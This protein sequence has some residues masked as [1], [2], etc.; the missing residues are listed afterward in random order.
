M[1]LPTR[2][3][4]VYA[5]HAEEKSLIQWGMRDFVF[6]GLRIAVCRGDEPPTGDIAVVCDFS[7]PIDLVME[8]KGE[9]DR[10]ADVCAI[11]EKSDLTLVYGTEM[12]V[13]GERRLSAVIA[14][15]G[16]LADVTDGCS[17]S[18]PFVA[19]KTV[20]IYRAGSVKFAV[21]LGGDARVAFIM[22][23]IAGACD[24]VVAIE[25]EPAAGSSA[26]VKYLSAK[27]YV[28]VLYASP[29]EVFFTGAELYRNTLS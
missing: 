25:P 16:R 28:P 27:L 14:R 3:A 24:F 17:V 15:R 26:R 23:K 2:S 12:I 18:P 19:S 22:K 1:F 5:E 7:H 11:S 21:L 6:N 4:F 9:T 20:K 8:A 13:F 29:N 10:L